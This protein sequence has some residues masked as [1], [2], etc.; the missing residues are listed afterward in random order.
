MVELLHPGS[1]DLSRA[2]IYGQKFKKKYV[3]GK[4]IENIIGLSI[5]KVDIVRPFLTRE[6]F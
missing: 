1:R 3:D 4:R 6:L 5:L 2:K